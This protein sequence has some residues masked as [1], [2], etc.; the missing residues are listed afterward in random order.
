MH[1]IT[2]GGKPAISDYSDETPTDTLELLHIRADVDPDGSSAMLSIDTS[3]GRSELSI[4]IEQMAATVS[5]MREAGALMMHR[6]LGCADKGRSA[7]DGMIRRAP[8]AAAV[9][10]TLCR[11]TG[12]VVIVFRFQDRMPFSVRVEQEL[13]FAARAEFSLEIKRSSN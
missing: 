5:E 4:T 12:D 6:Q 7:F 11:R 8:Q 1:G 2:A 9:T 10:L 3:E 13:F